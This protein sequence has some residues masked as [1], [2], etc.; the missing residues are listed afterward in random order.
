MYYDD[1][2]LYELGWGFH[3]H[4]IF[5]RIKHVFKRV[6]KTVKKV[7]KHAAHTVKKVAKHAVTV[8]SGV[9]G[10]ALGTAVYAADAYLSQYQN[11]QSLSPSSPAPRPVYRPPGSSYYGAAAYR[12]PAPSQGSSQWQKYLPW[13]AGAGLLLMLRGK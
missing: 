11:P 5:K 3:F 2:E 10:G 4:K 1:T 8:A 9:I 12:T 6:G 7:V 13:I